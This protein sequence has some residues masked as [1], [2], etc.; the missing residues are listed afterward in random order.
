MSSIYKIGKCKNLLRIT[1]I[2]Q[3]KNRAAFLNSS[4]LSNERLSIGS[5]SE[6]F[7]F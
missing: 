2:E 1:Q 3:M 6:L 7:Y 5:I 4:V